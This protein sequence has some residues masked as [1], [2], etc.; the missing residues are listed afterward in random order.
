M[1]TAHN[2]G[3]AEFSPDRR[4]RY[5]LWRECSLPIVYGFVQ[6]IGL[7][8]STAD[9]TTDDPTVTRMRRFA[10]LWG[11]GR[12]CVTN[13]F[14]YRATDP[15]HMMAQP[16]P[17]GDNNDDHILSV[18]RGAS[19]IVCAWGVNGEHMNREAHLLERLRGYRLRHLGLT[20]HGH[21][22]HPLYLRGDLR[23][24]LWRTEK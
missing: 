22:K 7:N 12:L 21:P 23:P 19:M 6:F 1:N 14:A 15:R 8:P 16:D 9:E 20:K 10:E 5:T 4:Y 3:A 18:A 24:E 13:A 11:Y 17:I 2:N